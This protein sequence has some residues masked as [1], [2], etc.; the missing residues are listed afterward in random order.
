MLKLSIKM[1]LDG[2]TITNSREKS[3]FIW[4][5]SQRTITEKQGVLVAISSEK[6][7]PCSLS[8]SQ[9]SNSTGDTGDREDTGDT[10]DTGDKGD[11]GGTGDTEDTGDTGETGDTG[12]TLD[13]GDTGDTVFSI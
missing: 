9:C 12:Y 7:E 3:R 8:Q 13:T 5:H 11:T 4:F 1:V 6:K 2:S 10:G